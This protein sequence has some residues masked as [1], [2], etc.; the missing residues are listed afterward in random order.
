MLF[1]T[2]FLSQFIFTPEVVSMTNDDVMILDTDLQK[3]E[4]IL[5]DPDVGKSLISK[6]EL[7]ASFAISKAENSQ[8]TLSEAQ[9]VHNLLVANFEYDFIGIK[10]KNKV[11]LTQKDHDKLEFFNIAK[12]F[13]MVS[14]SVFD[15]DKLN[16]KYI[17]DIHSQL[18]AGMD[19]FGEY[20]S[21]FTPYK[22]GKWR[23][24]DLV[25]VGSYVPAPCDQIEDGISELIEWLKENHNPIGVAVFHTAMYALHPFNNGNKRTCRILE[26]ILMRSIGLNQRNLYSESYY[27]H[28]EKAR[29]YKYLFYSLEHLNLNHFVSFVMEALSLSI[30]SVLKTAIEVERANFLDKQDVEVPVRSVLRPLVKRRLIQFKNLLRINRNKVSRQTLVNYLQKAVEMGII[31]RLAKGRN[32]YYGL[33]VDIP[34]TETLSKWITGARTKLSYVPSELLA[35][36]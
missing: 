16:K 4:K 14:Q 13:R 33:N 29:Y 32:T 8:L 11:K 23:S 20:L 35:L 25:Q 22:S 30:I 21:D 6:N 27:Y 26:H 31:T 9:E 36:L 3:Y 34:E 10:L 5:L 12:T 15:L 2:K 7:F 1:K 24:D 17:L 28:L 18:T 19:V